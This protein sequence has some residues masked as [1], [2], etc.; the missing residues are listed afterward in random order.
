M[1]IKA[2]YDWNVEGLDVENAY[3]EAYLDAEIYMN[4]FPEIYKLN[5]KFTKLN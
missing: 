3:L 2:E 1:H 4:I 5:G